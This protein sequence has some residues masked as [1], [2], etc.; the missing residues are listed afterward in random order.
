MENPRNQRLNNYTKEVN[1]LKSIPLHLHFRKPGHS[2]SP[3]AKFS[4][5][6]QLNNIHTTDKDTLKLNIPI[7]TP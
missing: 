4:L 1:N 5:I 2:F 7:T 6:E 3:H